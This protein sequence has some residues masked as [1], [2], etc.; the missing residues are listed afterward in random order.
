MNFGWMDND[1]DS[2]GIILSHNLIK[3]GH[4]YGIFYKIMARKMLKNAKI[5]LQ[6]D[7]FKPPSRLRSSSTN[8]FVQNM[9]QLIKRTYSCDKKHTSWPIRSFLKPKITK[10][11]QK[12]PK[13]SHLVLWGVWLKKKFQKVLTHNYK[14]FWMLLDP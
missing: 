14:N 2:S 10:I 4:N 11:I 3:Y 5:C 13:V 7:C 6:I 9:S 12:S 1:D 8:F